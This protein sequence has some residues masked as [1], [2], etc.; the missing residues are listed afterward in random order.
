MRR[1]IAILVVAAAVAVLVILAGGDRGPGRADTEVLRRPGESAPAPTFATG[2]VAAPPPA[3]VRELAPAVADAAPPAADT[4]LRIALL[5]A[6]DV[7]A[8]GCLVLV[9]PC[10][11]SADAPRAG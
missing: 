1:L 3:E 7:P 10:W 8:A 5:H 11:R 2:D 9:E 6:D 4:A